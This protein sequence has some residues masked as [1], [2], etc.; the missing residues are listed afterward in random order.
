[1][2]PGGFAT[3]AF[4]CAGLEPAMLMSQSS[5]RDLMLWAVTATQRSGDDDETELNTMTGA[6]K[7][8]ATAEAGLVATG[9]P[10][11][12][13]VVDHRL[14]YMAIRACVDAGTS[15]L[16]GCERPCAIQNATTH[17]T[18][19]RT[20]RHVGHHTRSRTHSLLNSLSNL[21]SHSHSL[22]DSLLHSLSRSHSLT[23][24]LAF[25]LTALTHSRTHYTR[26]H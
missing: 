4:S 21:L 6:L 26:S 15:T 17:S 20:G 7:I 1:M 2:V 13:S 10:A 16:C 19:S 18:S 8:L 11:S 23:L 9:S 3:T 22:T 25:A 14:V 5:R 24:A 12:A